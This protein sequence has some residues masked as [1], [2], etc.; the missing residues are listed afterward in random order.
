MA[1]RFVGMLDGE[2]YAL[3]H[4]GS[5]GYIAFSKLDALVDH[6][7]TQHGNSYL[8]KIIFDKNKTDGIL[9]KYTTLDSSDQEKILVGLEQ[10]Q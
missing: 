8:N 6:I 2:T 4:L 9:S 3:V 7:F 5:M 1:K 10:K